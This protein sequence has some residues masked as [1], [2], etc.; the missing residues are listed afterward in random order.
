MTGGPSLKVRS[1]RFPTAFLSGLGPALRAT[2]LLS[3]VVFW[4]LGVGRAAPVEVPAVSA[5][6]GPCTADF[7]VLNSAR[8]PLYNAKISVT[9]KYGFLNLWR[10]SLE[11]GTNSEGKA[12]VEGLPSK[13]RKHPLGF[14]VRS[15]NE[16]K[17]TE[18][19]P[20]VN[21]NVRYDVVLEK[22]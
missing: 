1:R 18:H 19:Y 22:N 2:L 7:T 21:C 13:V 6:L 3:G 11:V 4:G 8:K 5:D 20:A 9:I 17:T 15:G 16:V 14:V 12:R 10:I